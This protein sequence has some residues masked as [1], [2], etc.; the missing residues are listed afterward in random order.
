MNRPYYFKFFQRLDSTNFT[1]NIIEYLVPH[2]ESYFKRNFVPSQNL[3][4]KFL[5]SEDFSLVFF[6]F[7]YCLPVASSVNIT[8]TFLLW[9]S[10]ISSLYTIHSRGAL[11][12][13]ISRAPSKFC[14]LS[15]VS[16][17]FLLLKGFLSS[18]K[19]CVKHLPI[20]WP[21]CFYHMITSMFR[22]DATL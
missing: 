20:K 9:K 11:T 21:V 2:T 8:A 12:L 1:W 6:F 7:F 4:L 17:W 19:L 14:C 13:F 5:S 10:S 18:T 22:L 3:V 15:T 16:V